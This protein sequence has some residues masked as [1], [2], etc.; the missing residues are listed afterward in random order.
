MLEIKNLSVATD[1]KEILHNINLRIENGKVVIL[2]GPN[3]SGKTSLLM[4]IIGL[5]NYKITS[6]KIIFKDRDITN[7]PTHER[8]KLGIGVMFQRPPTIKGVNIRD[9]AKFLGNYNEEEFRS[10]AKLLKVEHLLERSINMGFSGGEIKRTELLQLLLQKPDLSLIDEP[11]SGVDVENI[12]LVG[13]A[14]KKLL[15]KTY[16]AYSN[17]LPM[18]DHHKKRKSSGLV[19]THTGLILEHIPADEGLVL[20]EG[21]IVCKGNPYE[22]FDTV[23]NKGFNECLKCAIMK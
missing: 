23:K 22:I 20:V 4:A 21:K 16:T 11:E 17:N 8:I 19:I 3:G 10:L 1:G 18:K 6:G 9:I 14:I 13:E 12:N 15:E 7:L 5:G 2:F